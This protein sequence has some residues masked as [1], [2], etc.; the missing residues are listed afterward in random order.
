MRFRH[1]GLAI[2][3][4][5]LLMLPHGLRAEEPRHVTFSPK[6]P[7]TVTQ[8]VLGYLAGQAMHSQW[9]AVA[10]RTFV[11]KSGSTTFYQDYLSIY[12]INGESTYDLKYR[13]PGNGGPLATVQKAHGAA[14]WFPLQNLN[15]VGFAQLQQPAVDELVVASH[16]ASADCG[17]AQVTIFSVDSKTGKVGPHVTVTNG[18]ALSARIVRGNG[19]RDWIE[20]TGPYYR[21]DAPMCCPTKNSASASLRFVGGKWKLSPSYFTLNAP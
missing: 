10:S 2:G 16:E 14:M 15:I 17:S 8:S 6:P 12:A 11:A 21:H 4:A 3:V 1:I 18:C 7:G 9:R 20:L 5:M 19:S 13:S